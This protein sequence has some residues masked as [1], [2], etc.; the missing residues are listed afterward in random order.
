MQ[1]CV[2]ILF[3]FLFRKIFTLKVREKMTFLTKIT[4]KTY[5]LK[6]FT[7]LKTRE[8]TVGL[9]TRQTAN[10]LGNRE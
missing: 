1:R 4:L 9:F 5:Y 8:K 7:L 10:L 3:I 2:R 6:T